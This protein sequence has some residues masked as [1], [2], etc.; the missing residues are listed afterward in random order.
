VNAPLVATALA[1]AKLNTTLRVLGRRADGFHEIDTTMVCVG[2]CDLVEA[3]LGPGDARST[4]D[5]AVRLRVSG[6]AASPDVREAPRNLVERAARAYLEALE[7]RTGLNVDFALELDLVKNVPSR[8][9]LGG[10]SADAAAALLAV[11]DVVAAHTGHVLAW[12]D[13][14]EQLAE[15]GSDTVYFAAARF[16]GLGR[17]T[18]RGER[19]EVLPRTL[20]DRE[21]SWFA[22]VVPDVGCST[23]SVYAALAAGA[24]GGSTT[25]RAGST[26]VNDLAAAAR[27][28]EPVLDDWFEALGPR[29]DLSGSGSALFARAT[30]ADEAAALA[31]QARDVA[32]RLGRTPRW[33]GVTTERGHGAR[34]VRVPRGRCLEDR[35]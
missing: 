28:V 6:S 12:A 27:S 2:P 35:P 30:T 5:R 16:T 15:L 31:E 24:G 10:A 3:R 26:L 33:C 25:S 19:V 7:T 22:L 20:S 14:L 23:P 18:G 9:G 34:L 29:F 21:R 13:C 4:E 11:R 1:P 32:Q 17:A 8:A